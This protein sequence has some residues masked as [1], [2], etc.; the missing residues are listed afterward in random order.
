MKKAKIIGSFNE[1][2]FDMPFINQEFKEI[3]NPIWHIDL[4][5]LV[6][7]AGLSGSQKA[8]EDLIWKKR[9]RE[10]SNVTGETAPLIW[11]KYRWGGR[12]ENRMNRPEGGFRGWLLP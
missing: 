4:R 12:R 7:R 5:F 2:I 8:V 1:S 6:K 11:Y 10:I 9:P 3:N